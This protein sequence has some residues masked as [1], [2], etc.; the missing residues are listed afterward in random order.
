MK[1]LQ[2]L[3]SLALRLRRA[4]NEDTY[5]PIDIFGLINGWQEKNITLIKYPFSSNISGMC[6][7]ENGEILI[8]INSTMSYGRQRFTLAHELYHALYQEDFS[9]VICCM[10]MVDKSD[11][12]KEADMFASYLLLPYDSLLSYEEDKE[13]WNSL[14]KIVEAEQFF[15]ISHQ[16]MLFRLKFDGILSEEMIEK[17]KKVRISEIATNLGYDLDLYKSTPVEKQFHTTGEYVRK[18]DKLWKNDLIS[19]GKK[20]EL[21]LDGFR[22]DIVYGIEVEGLNEYD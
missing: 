18:I 9:H 20:N 3:N 5:S 6:T 7:K 12:E 17:Y 1:S 19:E 2:E 4:L 22:S 13:K 14:D 16:A 11:S 10:S 21:L 8:C 15:Q